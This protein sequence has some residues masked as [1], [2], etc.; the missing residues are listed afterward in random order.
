MSVCPAIA[1]KDTEAPEDQTASVESYNLYVADLRPSS[2][3][4]AGDGARVVINSAVVT[5]LYHCKAV[6]MIR[7]LSWHSDV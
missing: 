5:Q 4:Y 3:V 7:N 2:V 6:Q 1:W